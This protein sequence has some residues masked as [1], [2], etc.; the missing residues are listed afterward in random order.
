LPPSPRSPQ[1]ARPILAVLL[2]ASIACAAA[3]PTAPAAPAVLASCDVAAPTEI[4][5]TRLL[6]SDTDCVSLGSAKGSYA[7]AFFDSRFVEVA[8]TESEGLAPDLVD[9]SV[10]VGNTSGVI[11]G[12]AVPA[13][14]PPSGPSGSTTD[15]PFRDEWIRLSGFRTGDPT[16]TAGAENATSSPEEQ[17]C[18]A[19]GTPEVFCRDRPWRAGDT[20]TIPP[21]FGLLTRDAPRAAEILSV[22]EPFVFA[23]PRDLDEASR[24]QLRTIL[25]RLAIVGNIRIVP[26][27]RRSFVDRPIYTSRGS[28]QL[29]VD[30][31][32]DLDAVCVCGVTISTVAHGTSVSGISI[33]LPAG[34]EFEAHRVGL[35]AHEL[36]HVWQHSYDTDRVFEPTVDLAP[37]TRW[38]VE[39]GADFVRQEILRGLA[40]EPLDGNRDAS[41][42]IADPFL[43][44]WVRDLRAASGQVRAGYGQSAGMLR[45]LFTRAVSG[46]D[47][48]D[49]ALQGILRGSLEGWFGTKAGIAAGPGLT[50]RLSG[51]WPEF[52]PTTALLEYA[53]ANA[54][55]DRI[56]AQG[57]S[58]PAVLDAWRSSP[59]SSFVPAAQIGSRSRGVTIRGPAGSLGYAYV[60]HA[61]GASVLPLQSSVEG[62][63]WMIVRFK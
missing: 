57:L 43:E 41:A 19:Q 7:V 54:I 6:P 10:S 48:Y 51:P 27:L 60:E 37:N 26:F 32:F 14:T 11:S 29:L 21:P 30:V 58:N 52:D 62:V 34:P 1:Y 42:P 63:R 22:R 28:Q 47:D 49:A 23:I 15:V 50:E 55:D 45:H 56:A 61:G 5:A 35:F 36:A 4:G 20:L 24:V 38:A 53:I 8:R 9:Y 16:P 33:R 12:A 59:G 25:A 3:D 18:R 2:L 31:T 39:G 46:G 40:D 44:R 13:M 17:V